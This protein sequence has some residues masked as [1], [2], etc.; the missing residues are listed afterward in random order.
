M[1]LGLLATAARG[2]DDA[3]RTS[4]AVPAATLQRPVGGA[5]SSAPSA[6]PAAS[7]ARPVAPAAMLDPHVLPSS[8]TSDNP[9]VRGASPEGRLMPVGPAGTDST[10]TLSLHG[11]RQ[12]DPEALTMPR[13]AG[14]SPVSTVQPPPMPPA[15]GSA[16]PSAGVRAPFLVNDLHP[17]LCDAT[18]GDLCLNDGCSHG[19][20][21][22]ADNRWY[23]GAEYL[24][25]WVKGDHV[26]VLVTT[27]SNAARAPGAADDPNAMVLFGDSHL[28]TDA[29]SGGRFTFG[30][31]F[32]CDHTVALEGVY[33]F[34]G[35][36]NDRFSATSFGSPILA[37]PFFD[38]FTNLPN[39]EQVANPGR[40]LGLGNPF[41]IPNGVGT[42]TVKH[43]SD[44]DGGELNLRTNPWCGPCWHVDLIGGFRTLRL[45][46][47]LTI[48]ENLLVDTTIP[49][50]I[51]NGIVSRDSIGVLDRFQTWNRFYGGQ[52]GAVGE[53]RRGDWTFGGSAKIALGSTQET[54][55]IVGANVIDGVA[56][57]GGLL[58]QPGFAN[59]PGNIGRFTRDSFS[60]VPELGL[61]IGYQ[62]NEH[63]RATLGYNILWWSGVVRPGEQIDGA[64]DQRLITG[65]APSA[66]SAQHPLFVFRDSTLWAQGM[67]LGLEYRY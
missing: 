23:A 8:F 14:S 26:P 16:P 60:V 57:P 11:W 59:Y 22:G 31:W 21:D 12:S 18:C 47:N 53:F 67:N 9:V 24:L 44:L 29:R 34:L 27:G 6:A 17:N 40:F 63:W 33:F 54:V 48:R 62:I 58:A 50:T 19:C 51:V 65:P 55:Q 35:Q 41:N 61:T 52:L 28:G 45:D 46:E 7:F 36:Q 38:S 3:W 15:D 32:G 64:V 20:C 39:S 49:P 4:P 37:R 30:Y 1:S 56:A 13:E 42:V 25:W 43:T 2:Q 66:A 5:P 10:P